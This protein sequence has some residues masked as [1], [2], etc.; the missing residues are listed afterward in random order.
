MVRVVTVL[1]VR[2]N[3]CFIYFAELREYLKSECIFHAR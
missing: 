2:K 3:K 1:S